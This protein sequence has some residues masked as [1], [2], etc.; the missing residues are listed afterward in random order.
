MYVCLRHVCCRRNA[1]LNG[2]ICG[3]KAGHATVWVSTGKFIFIGQGTKIYI[4]RNLF[5]IKEEPVNQPLVHCRAQQDLMV[6][7]IL[8][9]QTRVLTHPSALAEIYIRVNND[10]T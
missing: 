6:Q 3:S 9:A 5:E 1:E 7:Y 2:H 4:F 10:C 8:R